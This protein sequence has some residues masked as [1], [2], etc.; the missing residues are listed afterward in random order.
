MSYTTEVKIYYHSTPIPDTTISIVD[1]TVN[2]TVNTEETTERATEETEDD[3][4]SGGGGDWLNKDV[5]ELNSDGKFYTLLEYNYLSPDATETASIPDTYE[6][7]P[8]TKIADQAFYACADLEKVIIS[9]GIATI[10][11]YAFYHC[12]KFVWNQF[13]IYFRI[14]KRYAFEGCDIVINMINSFLG[15]MHLASHLDYLN[16]HQMDLIREGVSYYNTLSEMKKTATPYFPMGFTNFGDSIVCA[17]L[18]ND[19][20]IHLAVWNLKGEQEIVIPITE[21]ITDVEIAYPTNTSVQLHLSQDSIRL[22]CPE[23]PCAVF[24][25]ITI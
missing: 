7:F 17:G 6:G 4:D 16:E 14:I 13:P 3:D 2:E 19:S 24:L 1:A 20:K 21:G 11:E 8:V 23:T 10:G 22:T 12:D 5:P 18:K 9:E 25:E 15:R